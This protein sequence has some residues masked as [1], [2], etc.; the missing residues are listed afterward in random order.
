LNKTKHKKW[1]KK[2]R[3]D[4]KKKREA[5][6]HSKTLHKSEVFLSKTKERENVY[7]P[8]IF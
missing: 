4:N 8:F 3:R 1:L 6:F 7:P 5:N 2:R